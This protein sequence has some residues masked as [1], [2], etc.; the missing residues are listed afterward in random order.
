MHPSPPEVS[1]FPS[2]SLHCDGL[3]LLPGAAPIA[4]SVCVFLLCVSGHFMAQELPGLVRWVLG[5][6][7]CSQRWVFGGPA[8]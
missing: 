2:W 5:P 1:V 8:L 3:P 7:A 4:E 6:F